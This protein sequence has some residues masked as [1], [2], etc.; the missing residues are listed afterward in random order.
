M[1][2]IPFLEEKPLFYDEIDYARMP[3]AYRSVSSHFKL[4]Y[5]IHVI[6]T[7]GK[8]T[9]GR[10][11]AQMLLQNGLH[12]GHYTSPHIERFNE[13]IWIDGADVDDLSLESYHA[14]LVS[15][16]EPKMAQALSYFEY[17]TLLAMAIFC[18]RCDYVVLEAGLG[19]EFDATNVFPKMLS[20]VTPIGLD[21]QAFLGDTIEK[22]A[23]TK[24]NSI[25][26][27][28][29]LAKQYEQAVRDLAKQKAQTLHVELFDAET[30]FDQTTC[31]KIAQ[32]VAQYTKSPFLRENFQTALCAL[33]VLGYDI[34]FK[35]FTLK[36]LAGR[37][38]TILPNVTLDVGHNPMAAAAL[39]KAF[40]GKKVGLIYNSYKDKDYRT[41]LE[42]LKPVIEEILI[43]PIDSPRALEPSA[44]YEAA[45]DLALPVSSF[46]TLDQKK[47][48]LV[49]GSFSVAEAFLKG[50]R[51]R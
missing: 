51:E 41:I 50:L 26:T 9:T 20:V 13:R 10:F 18:D 33:R 17:T 32:L 28:F 40:E 23:T 19:G 45:R 27:H 47:E 6:G 15:W 5:I 1:Q 12:V 11:L 34:D 16:L 7:N 48:Y 35:A 8:G 37:H 30:F 39:A 4:P 31:E 46:T 49:F 3:L 25:T 14:R 29:V 22:I 24:L 2:L 44:L 36:P 38:Q 42:I 21:H 43:I